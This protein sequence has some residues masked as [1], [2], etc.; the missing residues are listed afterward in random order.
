VSSAVLTAADREA[1]SQAMAADAPFHPTP[2]SL[3]RLDAFR[4]QLA[5]YGP[6]S[7]SS[8]QPELV[9]AQEPAGSAVRRHDVEVVKV[10]EA[11]R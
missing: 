10:R 8:P 11:T 4:G 9:A 5:G 1:L 3:L 7:L 6:A 2:A